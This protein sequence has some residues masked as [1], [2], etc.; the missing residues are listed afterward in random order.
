MSSNRTLVLDHQTIDQKLRRIAYQIYEYNYREEE[1]VLVAIEKQ[2]VEL[3]NRIKPILEEISGKKF[4]ML[5]LKVDK[6]N[7]L[8]TPELNESGD[9]M[10]DRSVILVDDVLNSG[11]TL[12][13]GARYILEF[14]V[15]KLTTAVLVDRRHRR[16]PI[17]ADFAGLTLSTTLQDHISVVFKK[18]KDAVYLE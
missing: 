17:K 11:R 1:I 12:M 5:R 4:T 16:F 9:V 10:N 7:P 2:G 14:P 18:G 3:A 15:K 8:K 13:Y 6:K